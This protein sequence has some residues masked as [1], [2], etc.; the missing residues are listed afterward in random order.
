VAIVRLGYL[1]IGRR[2]VRLVYLV[3]RIRHQ[4]RPCNLNVRNS[5]PSECGREAYP[6]PVPKDRD[7]FA[8]IVSSD[9]AGSPSRFP[10]SM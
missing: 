9:D 10:L 1:E 5:L 2:I 4:R 7:G 8:L 3:R 6:K